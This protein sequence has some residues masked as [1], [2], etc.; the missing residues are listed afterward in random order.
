M[1]RGPAGLERGDLM[2]R[3]A[4]VEPRRP[5]STNWWRTKDCMLCHQPVW[6]GRLV[7]IWKG[8]TCHDDC[9]RHYREM[10]P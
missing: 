9:F 4:E 7:R 6:K 8:R 5:I 1:V 2:D 10:V 3:W